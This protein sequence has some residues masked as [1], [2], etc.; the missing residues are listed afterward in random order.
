MKN[1]TQENTKKDIAREVRCTICNV[2]GFAVVGNDGK[3]INRL[4]GSCIENV[5]G[6]VKPN[7][8]TKLLL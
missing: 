7:K 5:Y 8:Q 4:C 3:V 1:K 2:Y 6:K